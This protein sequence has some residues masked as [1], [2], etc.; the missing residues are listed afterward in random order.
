MACRVQLLLSSTKPIAIK[1]E[2]PRSLFASRRLGAHSCRA[3]SMA[4]GACRD[5]CGGDPVERARRKM[6]Y[7]NSWHRK[8]VDESDQVSWSDP[9]KQDA[10]VA[11]IGGGLSG[12][13]CAHVRTMLL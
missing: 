9:M 2:K 7:R 13:A 12:L 11:I 3:S 10:R 5:D 1:V 4:G 8:P 6:G